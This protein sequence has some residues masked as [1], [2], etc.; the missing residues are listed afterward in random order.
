MFSPFPVY[1]VSILGVFWVYS[2]GIPILV[3]LS[4]TLRQIW[5]FLGWRIIFWHSQVLFNIYFIRIQCIRYVFW[6][7][8][9]GIPILVQ[10]SSNLWLRC[11][12]SV[13]ILDKKISLYSW[14]ENQPDSSL[15]KGQKIGWFQ[16]IFLAGLKNLI[17]ALL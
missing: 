17:S 4:S 5:G 10:L 15:F 14:L 1:P 16:L 9:V 13:H 8:S 7:Y 3:Q 6:V 12:F 11:F 2:D